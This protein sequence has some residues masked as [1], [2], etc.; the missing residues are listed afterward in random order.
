M[1]LRCTSCWLEFDSKDYL[2]CLYCLTDT[3]IIEYKYKD[4]LK[5]SI[6]KKIDNSNDWILEGF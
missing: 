4:Y 5:E 1:R 6:N 3:V 2:V